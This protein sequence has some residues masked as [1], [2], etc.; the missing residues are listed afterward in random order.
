MN[1]F[2]ILIREAMRGKFMTGFK[3]YRMFAI[4]LPSTAAF[5]APSAQAQYSV[6]Y[7]FGVTD[8]SGNPIGAIAQGNRRGKL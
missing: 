7:S 8:D 2:R 3:N 5:A 1:G 6:I 4:A